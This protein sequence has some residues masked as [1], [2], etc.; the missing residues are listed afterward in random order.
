MPNM[1]FSVVT[2]ANW[3]NKHH[4]TYFLTG[5]K[6]QQPLALFLIDDI[7]CS[8]LTYQTL[9]LSIVRLG[10]ATHQVTYVVSH[11]KLWKIIAS[12]ATR[13]NVSEGGCC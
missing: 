10:L 9:Q 2:R 6:S 8:L 7:R 12:P 1:I 5:Q 13:Q 11:Q 3:E 4:I